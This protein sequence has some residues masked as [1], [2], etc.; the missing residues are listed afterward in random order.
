MVGSNVHLLHGFIGDPMHAEPV[1]W[2]RTP[3]RWGRRVGA[4]RRSSTSRDERQ[5]PRE[6]L[7]VSS[8]V[9]SLLALPKIILGAHHRC[10]SIGAS[11]GGL[12]SPATS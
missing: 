12:S 8:R 1:L 6:L 3:F 10:A 2:L 11:A 5:R 4:G 7:M 9:P